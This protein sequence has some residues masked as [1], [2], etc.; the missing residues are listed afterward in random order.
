MTIDQVTY[1]PVGTTPEKFLVT[2]KDAEFGSVTA[3]VSQATA[4]QTV[5]LTLT[6]DEGY[7]IKELRVVN[8]VFFTQGTDH[9]CGEGHSVRCR[10]R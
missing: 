4:G 1:E 2:V 8:S 9:P 10:S 6:P 7:D 3:D 5:Q